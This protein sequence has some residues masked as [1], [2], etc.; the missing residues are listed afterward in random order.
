MLSWNLFANCSETCCPQNGDSSTEVIVSPQSVGPTQ[1]FYEVHS[2]VVDRSQDVQR[3]QQSSAF[4]SKQE[5]ADT[6][7]ARPPTKILVRNGKAHGHGTFTHANGDVYH[8][9]WVNDLAHGVGTFTTHDGSSY[10][11]QWEQDLKS[12]T[13][14]ERWPD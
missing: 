3:S 5:E 1:V 9:E 14:E 8:G 11:G 7:Q 4:G 10:R 12:G 13:G 2:S 6:L